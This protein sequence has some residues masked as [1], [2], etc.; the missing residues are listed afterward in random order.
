ME[1]AIVSIICIA[2]IVVGGMTM[3]QSFLSSVD[4]T[5]LELEEVSERGEEILRTDLSALTTSLPSASILEVSLGNSGQTKLSD[6]GKWDVIVQYYDDGSSYHVRW[7]P[8]TDETP[9]DNE[10]TVK[11][12]YLDAGSQTPEVFESGIMNP[13]EEMIIEAKL[14]PSVGV[15][16]T[17]L[18][19]TSTPNGIPASITFSQ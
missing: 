10:W 13:G 2:L 15:E 16:T 9:G 3:S 5:T 6:F 7:L 1:T 4:S 8:Y 12:I 18:V 11:G 14:S 19:I 17:N